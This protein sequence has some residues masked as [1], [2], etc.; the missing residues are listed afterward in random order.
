M[1]R[2][3]LIRTIR[4]M[5][6]RD[7]AKTVRCSVGTIHA[8]EE[9]F[10]KPNVI[11]ARRIADTLEADLGLLFPDNEIYYDDRVTFYLQCKAEHLQDKMQLNSD[12]DI[13]WLDQEYPTFLKMAEIEDK[14]TEVGNISKSYKKYSTSKK[15]MKRKKKS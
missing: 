11:L 1:N 9:E 5:S 8:V 14:Y 10:N 6:L 2:V 15:G 3:R 12:F 13:N 7:L 4:G